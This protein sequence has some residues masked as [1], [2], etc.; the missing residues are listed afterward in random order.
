MKNIFFGFL[1]AYCFLILLIAGVV[2]FVALRIY[3]HFKPWLPVPVRLTIRRWWA[4][5]KHA[6]CGAQWPILASAGAAPEGWTGWPDGQKFVFVLTHDVES[7]RGLDRVRQLAE[8][9]IAHGW[10]SS[11]NFIPEGPYRVSPELR[12]WLIERGFEVGV[13]DHRHDGKLYKSRAHFVASARRINHFLKEWDAAGFRSGFM[14]HNLEWIKDLNIQYDLSTF[15]TDPFEP[16]PDGVKT[17]FPFWVPGH[18]GDGY[19]ELPYTLVQDSTLF[20]MLQQKTSDIWKRKLEWIAAQGGMALVNVHPDYVVF[21]DREPH[22]DEFAVA[23]YLEFLNWVR[24]AYGNSYWH[25]LPRDVARF[26]KHQLHRALFTILLF[27]SEVPA[28][29]LAA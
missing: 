19:M 16:Q 26:S 29:L 1:R 17:I 13:H 15:D 28:L 6:R 20:V 3:Y 7:Q 25:A 5:R 14:F 12:Q 9:E 23:H 24:D 4:R 2:W 27:P 21:G 8:L 11:F 22:P 10:R 18:N